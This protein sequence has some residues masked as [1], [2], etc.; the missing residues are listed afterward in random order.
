MDRSLKREMNETILQIELGMQ[1]VIER[2][3]QDLIVNLH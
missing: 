1:S 2:L 3:V